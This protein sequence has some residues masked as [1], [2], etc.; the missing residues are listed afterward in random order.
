MHLAPATIKSA[1]RVLGTLTKREQDIC[2]IGWINGYSA[3]DVGKRNAIDPK[4]VA[5][6]Y[7]ICEYFADCSGDELVA[8][9]LADSFAETEPAPLMPVLR[10][11]H[12]AIRSELL[13]LRAAL[14]H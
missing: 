13:E 6:A 12:E 2:S 1:A 5:L 3:E 8:M 9:H 14:A 11:E 7:A 10:R 4:L